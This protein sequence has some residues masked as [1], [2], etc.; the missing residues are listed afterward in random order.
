MYIFTI[1]NMTTKTNKEEDKLKL[2]EYKEQLKHRLILKAK[3]L[4]EKTPEWKERNGLNLPYNHDHT[5][6][7]K[8]HDKI[9]PIDELPDEVL[10]DAFLSA[11][12][13]NDKSFFLPYKDEK[14][15]KDISRIK[16]YIPFSPSLKKTLAYKRVISS[17][18]SQFKAS[19]DEKS[20][21]PEL[22][23]FL[24]ITLDNILY[25]FRE[26][27]SLQ[28]TVQDLLK[29]K[30]FNNIIIEHAKEGLPI[31]KN[32]TLKRRKNHLSQLNKKKEMLQN[33]T[34]A[35]FSI[36]MNDLEISATKSSIRKKEPRYFYEISSIHF[37]YFCNVCFKL[38]EKGFNP[39]YINNKAQL[40]LIIEKY[41]LLYNNIF[42]QEKRDYR[43]DKNR[44]NSRNRKN[45]S[46][47]KYKKY[48]KIQ[49]LKS[50]GKSKIEIH[51]MEGYARPTIDKYWETNKEW[52]DLLQS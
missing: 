12:K 36:Y 25:N 35:L 22:L 28:L 7:N 17:K 34:S 3:E 32:E 29:Q 1:G 20:K 11:F 5:K 15:Y 16:G 45:K 31:S 33:K 2:Q 21:S 44:V 52:K 30:W 50:E 42:E 46:T 23:D 19:T 40:K 24:D 41:V 38:K 14:I 6:V 18:I 10:S 37:E 8:F 47:E 39:F 26:I 48:L 43:E 13:N 51:R 4:M 27:K 49:E 9:F